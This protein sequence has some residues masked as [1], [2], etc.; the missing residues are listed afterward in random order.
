MDYYRYC[1]C[2]N[3]IT[4][5]HRL[6]CQS[7]HR[8]IGSCRYFNSNIGRGN[9]CNEKQFLNILSTETNNQRNLHWLCPHKFPV[10]IL[11]SNYFR[12][13]IDGWYYSLDSTCY[14]KPLRH[15]IHNLCRNFN[16][17]RQHMSPGNASTT[18]YQ[19]IHTVWWGNFECRCRLSYHHSK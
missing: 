5:K 10:G 7:I 3:R 19:F 11:N 12:R 16:C 13:N 18:Q 4:R 1:C 2:W 9:S 14:P 15:L 8:G 17:H 6:C